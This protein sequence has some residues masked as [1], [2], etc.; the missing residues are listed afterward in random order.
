MPL[1]PYISPPER[2]SSEVGRIKVRIECPCC[3][4]V[5]VA[6]AWSLAGSGKRC[7]CGAKLTSG[8]AIPPKDDPGPWGS[9]AVYQ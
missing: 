9:G 2:L 1:L 3:G 7:P 8:G 5:T 4:V 6:Y